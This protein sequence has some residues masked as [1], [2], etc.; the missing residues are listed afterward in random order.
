M[1]KKG[2]IVVLFTIVIALLL[3]ACSNVQNNAEKSKGKPVVIEFAAG[4]DASG[5]L[6]KQ[7]ARFN[8][9]HKDIQVKYIEMPQV[10]NDQFTRY[11]TWFNSKSQTP[12]LL[13]TDVTW[14]SMFASAG[15]IAPIDKYVDK[16]YLK[17]F[18]PAAVDVANVD[19]KQYGIQ[20]WLDLGMVYYR[21]DLLEKYNLPVPKTWSELES[22]SKEILAKEKQKQLAGYVFQGAK[23]E[24]ATINW[25]EFLWGLNGDIYDEKGKV[26]VDSSKGIEALTTMRSLI[27]EKVSPASVSTS[28]PNDNFITFSSG[29][30][31]FMRNWPGSYANLKGTKVDGKFGVTYI[32]SSEGGESHSATGGWVYSINNNSEHKK[33]AWEVMKYFLSDEE[34]KSMAINTSKIPSVKKVFEDKEVSE[35]Q[36]LF[37]ILPPF[38]EN[39]KS[40]P[41]LR[42]YDAFS[43]S[44]Q[45]QVN[46]VLSG[47]KDPAKGLQDAQ[48]EIEEKLKE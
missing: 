4:K 11:S 7:I 15:W 3:S 45:T 16:D 40:R 2:F 33:E 34:Q 43:L 18:W 9:E 32:P 38:L 6:E 25:L 1:K 5:D 29:N 41:V 48:K 36:P 14:P 20:G 22:V 21:K 47:Q 46:L 31:I 27:D 23:I 10:P 24:G 13:M 19:G 44:V 12:D 28:N 8:T 39:A 30:A 37:S 17:R 42:G 26:K 35:A